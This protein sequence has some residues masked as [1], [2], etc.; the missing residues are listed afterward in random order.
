MKKLTAIL[1][2]VFVL[3][4]FSNL[5]LAWGGPR[6]HGQPEEFRPGDSRGYFIWRDGDTV[7]LRV[8]TYGR[9]HTF[10]GVIRTD[11]QFRHV[12]GYREEA[13]DFHR[14]DRDRD[15]IAFRFHTAGGVDGLDFRVDDADH[16]AFDLYMDGHPISPGHIYIGHRGWHPDDNTFRLRR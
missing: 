2:M 6:S 4:A 7:H 12:R 13:N 11:G 15:A 3:L 16:I 1:T 5:A 8:T 10:S 9:E 14:V